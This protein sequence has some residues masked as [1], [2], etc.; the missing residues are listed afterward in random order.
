[1]VGRG[2]ELEAGRRFVAA[3]PEGARALVFCGDAG[4]G[5]TAVWRRVVDEVRA[6]GYRVLV[7]RCVEAEMPLGFAAL[8]ICSRMRSTMSATSFRWCSEPPWITRSDEAIL[9]RGRLMR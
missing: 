2:R 1:L 8:P 9:A 5:K 7:A 3:L 6:G 4:I